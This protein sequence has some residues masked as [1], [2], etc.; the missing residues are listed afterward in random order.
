MRIRASLAVLA[1]WAPGALADL[2]VRSLLEVR[3]H[4]IVMQQW[5]NSC[6]AAALATVLTYHKG[7]PVTERQVA[8]GLLGETDPNRVRHRGGFSLLDMKRYAA[9]IGFRS[10]AYARMTLEDLSAKLPAIVP[11][12]ARG[13]DHFVV[14]QRIENFNVHIADPGFGHYTLS[15]SRFAA[16]WPGIGFVLP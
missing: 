4:R 12:R 15:A 6:G 9:S 7:F 10:D 1:L 14:V 11:V 13:Y 3:Q 8:Q 5:D 16:A 2:P